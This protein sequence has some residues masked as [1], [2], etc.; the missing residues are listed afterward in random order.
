MELPKSK[1][2][3]IRVNPRKLILFGPPKVGK[4]S[5]VANL[6]DCLLVE[7]EPNGADFVDAMTVQASSVQE[8]AE[9]GKAIKKEGY[10]YKYVAIDTITK[11]EEIILPYAATLYK[12]TP[13]GSNWTGSDVRKLPNGS[14]YLYLREAF[15]KVLEEIY[16]WADN[17]ILIGHLKDKLIE[18]KGE[19]V[20]A[21]EL[22]LTGKI[23]SIV[24]ADSDA[25]GYLYRK[26]NNTILS[27]K[28]NDQ[29]ICGARSEHLRNKEFNVSSLD[30][31]GNVSF[32]WDGIYA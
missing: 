21:L 15:F 2:K 25:I 20:S 6:P 13:M 3:A 32:S 29:V 10:P 9:I 18:K 28:T 23:K 27:F 30:E 22:D 14:G 19:E 26:D 1:R 17:I 12:G 24:A 5:L 11:L 31:N 7:L 4:T 16:T 8:L